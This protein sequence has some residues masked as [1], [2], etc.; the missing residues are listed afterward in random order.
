MSTAVLPLKRAVWIR[1]K[2]VLFALV[3]LMVANE[4]FLIDAK[5]PIW[6]HDRTIW[7]YLLP[8]GMMGACALLLGPMQFSD[9]LRARFTKLH[10]VVGRF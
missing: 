2:D 8:H 3:G 1:P 6:P 4:H 7:W 10:R 9:R 5:D